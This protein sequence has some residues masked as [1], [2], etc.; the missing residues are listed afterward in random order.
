MRARSASV[1]DI[2]TAPFCLSETGCPG[3]A[4]RRLRI[5]LPLRQ[6]R[7]V[8]TAFRRNAPPSVSLA[9][10]I[11]GG[12]RPKKLLPAYGQREAQH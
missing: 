10:D 5:L 2:L 4:K 3:G 7:L 1:A 9:F 11:R 12:H 6:A 8:A